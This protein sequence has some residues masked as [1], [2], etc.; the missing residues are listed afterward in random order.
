MSGVKS[1]FCNQVLLRGSPRWMVV[2][3]HT[4]LL[5]RARSETWQ[6]VYH[7]SMDG[8]PLLAEQRSLEQEPLLVSS[9]GALGG[10]RRERQGCT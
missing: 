3:L 5:Q 10:G 9:H 1:N 8:G 6:R 7:P 4:R 2:A